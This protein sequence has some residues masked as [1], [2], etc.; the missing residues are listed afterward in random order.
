MNL[1]GDYIEKDIIDDVMSEFKSSGALQ[2]ALEADPADSSALFCVTRTLTVFLELAI[3]LLK[4]DVKTSP[5]LDLEL[6][7]LDRSLKRLQNCLEDY[8]T[9]TESS[10]MYSEQRTAK[11]EM[12]Q[13]IRK[14]LFTGLE[15]AQLEE[16]HHPMKSLCD[17]LN[18]ARLDI[19]DSAMAQL[20][21]ETEAVE[22]SAVPQVIQEAK[23]NG[24]SRVLGL[25]VEEAR[26]DDKYEP[27]LLDDYLT[28]SQKYLDNSVI[29]LAAFTICLMG[30][31][32]EGYANVA[33]RVNLPHLEP[34]LDRIFE[35][36][37]T[38]D[39]V[40]PG[41]N[42]SNEMHGVWAAG[43]GW[44]GGSHDTKATWV[45][46]V[47]RH[48]LVSRDILHRVSVIKRRSK[49]TIF[50]LAIDLLAG[51]LRGSR[52]LKLEIDSLKRS[53]KRLQNCQKGYIVPSPPDDGLDEDSD[54]DE[55]SYGHP[56]PTDQW[57]STKEVD[58]WGKF[59]LELSGS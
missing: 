50:G 9:S 33:H 43:L 47:L 45:Q 2:R 16:D 7:S 53:L 52:E 29:N 14:T 28:P 37:L 21:H 42:A 23:A 31:Q 30:L 5:F 6:E 12:M 40:A 59:P 27:E 26:A 10:D 4:N 38:W 35:K 39:D 56:E 20:I 8:K 41:P 25:L 36:E 19:G 24:G 3:K 58:N 11:F 48:E 51:D 34:L 57:R 18:Q 17:Y 13:S 49:A 1:W 44:I 55:S 32:H 15:R 46:S 22:D 54:E